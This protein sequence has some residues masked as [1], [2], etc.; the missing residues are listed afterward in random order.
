MHILSPAWS[1]SKHTLANI[2]FE[3]PQRSV[4][5]IYNTQKT[6]I[7]LIY[8]VLE[9]LFSTTNMNSMK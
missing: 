2:R 6:Q 9:I 5:M 8:S 4:V 3:Q 1:I 7:R